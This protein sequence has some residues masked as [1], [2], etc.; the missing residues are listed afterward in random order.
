MFEVSELCQAVLLSIN[1]ELD[2]VM[3]NITQESYPS[4]FDNTANSFKCEA[5]EVEAYSWNEKYE[6]PYNFKWREFEI[7]WYKYFGRGM[8]SNIKIYND[9]IE[10]MLKECLEALKE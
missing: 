2:R 6:Q 10:E 5:F 3:W 4:P 9:D 1:R 8:S 7:S